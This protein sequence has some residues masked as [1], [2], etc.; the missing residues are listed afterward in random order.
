MSRKGK[1]SVVYHSGLSPCE[2]FPFAYYTRQW[3]SLR[4]AQV[5]D[6]Q[7]RCPLRVSCQSEGTPKA[8]PKT[9]PLEMMRE[10]GEAGYQLPNLTES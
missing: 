4:V 3:L 1:L 10:G 5:R 2:Y 6:Q 9:S 7:G 8:V